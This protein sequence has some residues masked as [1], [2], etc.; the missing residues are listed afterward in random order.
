MFS[1][2]NYIP[3]D[4]GQRREFVRVFLRQTYYTYIQAIPLMAVLGVFA[5]LSVALQARLGLSFMGG[6]D[7][8]GQI[9][10]MVLIRELAPLMSSLVLIARSA[11]AVASELATMKVQQEIDALLVMGININQYLLGPRI[12]A[13]TVSIFCMAVVF[14]LAGL[15]GAWFGTNFWSYFPLFQFLNSISS[16]LAPLDI[17]FFFAKTTI[18][19]F[20]IFYVAIKSGLS[21]KKAPF[22]VPIVTNKAVVDSLF[23][24]IALQIFM[25]GIFYLWI[26]IKM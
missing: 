2:L 7:S 13:A 12:L 15:V 22:E 16:S 4:E 24:A 25:S 3:K 26:G 17:F 20:A 11:T 10:V 18:I 14:V 6:N 9:V 21:L 19:G 5:G 8:L 23:M 1:V